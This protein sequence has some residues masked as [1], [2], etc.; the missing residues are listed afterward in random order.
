MKSQSAQIIVL[1]DISIYAHI[2]LIRGYAASN[3]ATTNDELIT[4]TL[5]LDIALFSLYFVYFM[6]LLI[7]KYV[8]IYHYWCV[9]VIFIMD[10]YWI[11]FYHKTSVVHLFIDFVFFSI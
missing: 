1:W 5:I 2:S 11:G 8:Y 3:Y 10:D 4:L 7:L 9:S 6:H